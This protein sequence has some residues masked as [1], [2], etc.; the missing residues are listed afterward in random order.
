MRVYT[1]KEVS[2][3]LQI[4]RN[5]TYS[6]MKTS[7]FPSYQIGKQYFVTEEALNKWLKSA[8]HK[9]FFTSKC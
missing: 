8:E 2:E 6:L 1:A 4:G 5:L 9:T 3:L 7:G